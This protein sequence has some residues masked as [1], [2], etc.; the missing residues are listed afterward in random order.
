MKNSTYLILLLAAALVVVC[1]KWVSDTRNADNSN[2]EQNNVNAAIENIMTR[3]SIRAY[4]DR[5]ISDETLDTIMRAAMAAPSA[6]NKQPWRFVVVKDQALRDSISNNMKSMQMAKNAQLSILVCGDMEA[7]L[8]VDNGRDF[9]IQDVS[10]VSENILLA[11]NALGLGA[12]WCGIYPE[13]KRVKWFQTTF[14]MPENIVPLSCINIGY[15]AAPATPK[16]KWKPEYIHYDTW[17][18]DSN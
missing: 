16:D 3:T 7:A 6:V 17:N 15:P 4:S 2:M 1:Y 5:E 13:M 18:G 11:A 10:A 8:P 12:V 9:W 14:E